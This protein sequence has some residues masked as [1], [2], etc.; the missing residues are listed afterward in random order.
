MFQNCTPQLQDMHTRLQGLIQCPQSYQ[1]Y[2]MHEGNRTSYRKLLHSM[3]KSCRQ[4]AVLEPSKNKKKNKTKN[5]S[6]DINKQT[7]CQK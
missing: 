2:A 3:A 6:M 4:Q 5:K 1:K 7:V